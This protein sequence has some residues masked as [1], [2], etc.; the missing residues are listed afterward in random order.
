MWNDDDVHL[1]AA[2]QPSEHRHLS[3]STSAS[4][5]LSAAAE[6]A[7]VDFNLPANQPGFASRQFLEDR[8]AQ[9]VEKE[10][11][12]IAIYP[13]SIL[14]TNALWRPSNNT[15]KARSEYFSE[16]YFAALT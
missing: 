2:F 11:R 15:S 4:L 16:A 12:R 3:G 1:A 7:L 13:R 10:D 9:L 14:P 5:A 6:I 8:L